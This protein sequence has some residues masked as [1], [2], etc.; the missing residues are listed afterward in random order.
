V[1]WR[2]RADRFWAGELGVE[3]S[4]FGSAGVQVCERADPSAPQRALVVGTTRGTI[5]SLPAAG[6]RGFSAAGLDLAALSRQ[7]RAYLASIPPDSP[8]LDVR[9]PAYLGYWPLPPPP[10]GPGEELGLDHREALAR[11]RVSAPAEWSEAGLDSASW[12]FGSVVGDDLVAAAGY[13][14][15][16]PELAHLAVFC[17]PDHRR[18]GQA[19]TA[20]RAAIAHAL[21]AGLLPQYRARDGN[22]AS[23]AL[24]ERLGFAEYGWMATVYLRER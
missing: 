5:V 1:S 11:L 20:L 21:G 3:A 24:A 9:G 13:Q 14:C 16:P 17:R 15:W 2:Y 4:R 23:R 12:C 6:L 19:A 10:A 18:R 8:L 22:V 7:G